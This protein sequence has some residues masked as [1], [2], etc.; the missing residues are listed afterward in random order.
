[1]SLMLRLAANDSQRVDVTES[2]TFRAYSV[3]GYIGR[4]LTSWLSTM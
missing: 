4:T 3:R 1:M 2:D